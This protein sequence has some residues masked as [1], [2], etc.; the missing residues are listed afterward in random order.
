MLLIW[1]IVFEG[2]RSQTMDNDVLDERLHT[3]NYESRVIDIKIREQIITVVR[4][5]LEIARTCLPMEEL[6]PVYCV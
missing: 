2:C 1:E 3:T 6:R 4:G 5:R